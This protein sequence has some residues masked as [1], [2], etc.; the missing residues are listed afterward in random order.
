MKLFLIT[1]EENKDWD[2]YQGAIVCAD[3]DVEARNMNPSSGEPMDW[4]DRRYD[5]CSTPEAVTVK[6]IGEPAAGLEKGV[7]LSDYK[8]G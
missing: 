2:T 1:Q 7:I 5:W 6:Y 8:A 4:S 3:D